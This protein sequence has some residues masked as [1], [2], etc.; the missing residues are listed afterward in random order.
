[1]RITLLAAIAAL[2]LR[3]SAESPLFKGM[4]YL[5]EIGHLNTDS[6]RRTSVQLGI[7]R[8]VRT[9]SGIRLDGQDDEAKVWSASI[10]IEGGIGW[11]DVWIADFDGNSRQ[12]FLIASF[13][14]ANG[15]C[16]DAIHLTFL[17]T[18]SDGRP[19][20]WSIET[21]WP[22]AVGEG[23]KP[24]LL[25]DENHNGRAEL[26]ATECEYAA[27]VRADENRRIA[28]IYEAKDAHWEL[29]HPQDLSAFSAVFRANYPETSHVHLLP[30]WPANNEDLGNRPIAGISPVTL[31]DILPPVPE[32]SHAVHLPPVVNGALQAR[33]HDPCDE[34]RHSRL[35]LS[36]GSACYYDGELTVVFDSPGGREIF[37]V[38]SEKQLEP[39]LRRL[40]R[41]R[42]RMTLA[43]QRIP[44]KCSPV[45]LWAN[46]R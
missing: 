14:P 2:A 43:G 8:A 13:F 7:A 21:H 33:E 23:K 9:E 19:V 26:I 1:M 32:C 28:G 46:V 40:M 25:V 36:D 18:D 17:M 35:M 12:D 24:A 6:D 44:G 39:T 4:R 42:A 29:V 3:G 22:K 45:M 37:K 10:P 5:G 41:L 30:P 27:G 34:L 11:T 20:P 15:R 38:E 31:K 16:V